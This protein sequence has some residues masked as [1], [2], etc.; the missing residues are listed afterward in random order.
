MDTKAQLIRDMHQNLRDGLINFSDMAQLM[1]HVNL[2]RRLATI[3]IQMQYFIDMNKLG[4]N[5][6]V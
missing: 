2:N 5:R 4:V 3:R 1:R 6:Y